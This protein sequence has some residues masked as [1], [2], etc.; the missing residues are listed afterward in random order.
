[1]VSLLML[2]AIY[3]GASLGAAGAAAVGFGVMQEMTFA[4]WFPTLFGALVGG[5][6]VLNEVKRC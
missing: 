3:G 5:I 1:M 2:L 6:I 4:L